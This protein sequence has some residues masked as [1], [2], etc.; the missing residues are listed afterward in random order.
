MNQWSKSESFNPILEHGQVRKDATARELLGEIFMDPCSSG[1]DVMAQIIGC[2][3][4]DLDLC[5][6]TIE[7][8]DGM[9]NDVISHTLQRARYRLKIAIA[10]RDKYAEA[11]GAT[12]EETDK[13]IPP[14]SAPPR[15]TIVISTPEAL[16]EALA[17]FDAQ[18]VAP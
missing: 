6:M 14:D 5:V 11:D 16:R 13:V 2:I 4:D 9:M 12:R 17:T 3:A 1:S 8:A 10:L 18:Q 7:A 15:S